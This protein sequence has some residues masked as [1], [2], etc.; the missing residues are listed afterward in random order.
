MDVSER[1]DSC[2]ITWNPPDLTLDDL[3]KFTSL[4]LDLHSEVAI[5]YVIAEDQSGSNLVLPKSPL[6]TSIRMGSPLVAELLSAP[7]RIEIAALGAVGWILKNQD[8]LSEFLPRVRRTW[9]EENTRRLEARLR[10]V[11][12]RARVQARG[13]SIRTFE[14]EYRSGRERTTGREPPGREPPGRERPGRDG[15]SR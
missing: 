14:R 3:A 11:E 13:R 15:R 6:V 10:Y 4:L 8:K 5:P 2:T 12:T 1:E 7:E 9:D